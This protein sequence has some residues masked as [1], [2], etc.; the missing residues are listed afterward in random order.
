[1]ESI[2]YKELDKFKDRHTFGLFEAALATLLFIIFNFLFIFTY[3]IIPARIRANKFVYYL[4]SFLVE[5]LFGLVAIVVARARKISIKEEAGVNKKVSGKL[6]G[7]AFLVAIVC[8]FFLSDLT[9]AFIDLLLLIGYK[10]QLSD[11]TISSFWQYLVYIIISCITPA[12]CE[13][14]LFRGVIASG[15]KGLG[16]TIAVVLSATIFMLMHGNPEQTIHQ[17]L[18][19]LVI[20]YIFIS[21]GNLWIGV[22]I[23]FFN[24]FIS[25]TASY[26][27]TLMSSMIPDVEAG[28][29]VVSNINPWLSFIV[30]LAFAVVLALAGYYILKI[31]VKKMKAESDRVNKQENANS[32]IMV[33]GE[34]VETVITTSSVENPKEETEVN[35]SAEAEELNPKH[36]KMSTITVIMFVLSGIYL[37]LD[38]LSALLSG[39]GVL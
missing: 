33:D 32:T 25:V 4:A 9:S 1:M 30:E 12:V 35:S 24:N 15:L 22:L 21:T 3:G 17:F 11:L 6:V 31:I 18:I 26:A 7:L 23:H 13:E 14:L 16:K 29:V 37:I 27:L 36:E 5:A 39:L 38:W 8:L 34:A 2:I 19:G 28:E 10:P 20:G